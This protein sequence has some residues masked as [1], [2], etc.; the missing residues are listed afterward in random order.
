MNRINQKIDWLSC[1]RSMRT[2]RL[3]GIGFAR[4]RYRS[5]RS[6]ENVGQRKAAL[7]IAGLLEAV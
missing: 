4:S 6:K 5:A 7:G 3:G 1:K 2:M